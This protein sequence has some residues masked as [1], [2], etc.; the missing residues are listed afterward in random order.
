METH[1]TPG[2]WLVD[3]DDGVRSYVAQQYEERPGG[4]ICEVFQNCLVRGNT[5]AANACLIAAA[6]D[7]LAA[8]DGL[9]QIIELAAAGKD[10]MQFVYLES[11]R[12]TFIKVTD[13]LIAAEQAI[14]KATGT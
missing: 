11:R 2:P 6:P 7:L 8:V 4:R 14:A 13:A 12:G 5:Q 10:D 1:H 3:S 9:K